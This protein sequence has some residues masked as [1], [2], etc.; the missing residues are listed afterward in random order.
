[1]L[2]GKY[3]DDKTREPYEK[4]PLFSSLLVIGMGVNRSFKDEP[5]TVSGISFPLRQP[6]KIG[7]KEISRLPVHFYNQDATLAPAGK[8]TVVVMLESDYDYWITLAK[9]RTTYTEYKEQ[10]AKT[11]IELLEQRFPESPAMWK[12]WMWQHLN[13]R[14]LYR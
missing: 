8:T 6:V 12:W 4:W 3:A 1:M 11:V 5:V 7:G 10:A 9:D 14:T 13:L 2:E